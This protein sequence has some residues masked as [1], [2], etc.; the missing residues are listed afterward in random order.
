MERYIL[1]CAALNDRET[2]HDELLRALPLPEYYG[3]NLDALWDEVSCMEAEILL[4]NAADADGYGEIILN[5]LKEAAEENSR[6][7][8]TIQA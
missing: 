7:K 2:A 6:L 3:R 5:L 8:L 4:K 1:N